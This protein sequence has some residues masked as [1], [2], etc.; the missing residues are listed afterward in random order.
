MFRDPAAISPSNASSQRS[1]ALRLGL[2]LACGLLT[3]CSTSPHARSIRLPSEV[4]ID[5]I[6]G[7]EATDAD[8]I[9][10]LATAG[11][12]YLGEAHTIARHH[13]VQLAVLQGIFAR[14]TDLTLCLEQLEA[15]DQPAVD[16]YNRQEID[17]DTLARE[18]DWAKKWS[19]YADYRALCE[20]ARQHRIPIQALNAPAS[21]I[22]AVSRGG[23]LAKLPADQRAQLP[24]D[25]VLTDPDYE[26]RVSRELSIHM[27]VDPAKVR[28][29]FEAQVSRDEAMAARIVAAR[30]GPD[31]K[32][33]TAVVLLGAG[34][35]R[36]GFGTPARVQRR[37]PGVIER[38]VLISDSG[39]L[40][41]SPAEKAASREVTITHEELRALG[42]P[43]ADYLRLLPV[44]L[45]PGHPPIGSP[46]ASPPQPKG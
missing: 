12:V 7:E 38:L 46:K 35:M 29:M 44:A 36:F 5:L 41:L 16:R 19:N 23:G 14:R 15:R 40:Q 32:A 2:A 6:E 24:D 18:I 37:D 45:P 4:W 22:R 13:A 34:H 11:V 28:P 30:H 21:V 31:G 20:F 3:A 25:I 8:V 27:A 43:P 39:Q 10:D 17:F 26:K 9:E 1:A 33:R 42:R